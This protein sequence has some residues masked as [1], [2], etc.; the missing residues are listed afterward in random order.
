MVTEAGLV[1]GNILN[2]KLTT[3]TIENA[4]A[5]LQHQVDGLAML[6]DIKG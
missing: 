1:A 3:S 5:N 6:L 4:A 2:I